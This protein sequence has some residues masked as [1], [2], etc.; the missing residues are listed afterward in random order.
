MSTAQTLLGVLR[1][2]LLFG[3]IPMGAAALVLGFMHLSERDN[4]D[5]LRPDSG[6]LG[7]VGAALCGIAVG[8]SLWLLWFSWGSPSGYATWAIVGAVITALI[9][10]VGIGATSRWRQTGPFVVALGGLF[11]FSSA[12]AVDAGFY[13]TTGLWGVGYLMIVF[14]AGFILAVVATAVVLVRSRSSRHRR[15]TGNTG[16]AEGVES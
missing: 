11:G 3:G 16:S 1:V 4:A 9:A 5:E 8:I 15:S 12:F 10:V 13:D 14:I 7:N 6:A 2:I